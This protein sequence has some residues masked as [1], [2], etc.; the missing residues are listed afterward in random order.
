[1]QVNASSDGHPDLELSDTELSEF[2]AGTGLTL[3]EDVRRRQIIDATISAIAE[4]G[5][6]KT[7]FARIVE[8]AGLS[9]TRMVSYHFA[10]KSDLVQATLGTIV[11]RQDTFVGERLGGEQDL[12]RLL[13]GQLRA[14][15]AFLATHPQEST[16]LVEIGTHAATADDADVSAQVVHAIRVGRFER[17]LAQGT[18]HGVFRECDPQIMALTMRQAIDGVVLRL[19]QQP[20]LDLDACGRELADLF[21]R[22]VRAE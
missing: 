3:T 22:A 11:D 15:V 10:G 9:S 21:D 13:L 1:M 14:E 16:A 12:R 6:V 4:L 7:S 19:R 2:G 18:R 5:Y 8:R 17:L 20:S